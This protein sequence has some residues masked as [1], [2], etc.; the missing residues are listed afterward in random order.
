MQEACASH[1]ILAGLDLSP[2]G[3]SLKGCTLWCATETTTREQIESLV[4]CWP[5]PKSWMR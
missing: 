2:Y 5:Y 1:D 4:E 3:G